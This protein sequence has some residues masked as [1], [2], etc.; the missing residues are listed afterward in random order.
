MA[1]NG[2]NGKAAKAKGPVVINRQTVKVVP[3]DEWLAMQDEVQKLQVGVLNFAVENA[4]LRRQIS[5]LIGMLE[6]NELITR[7][8]AI[9]ITLKGG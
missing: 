1:D 9:N 7:K 5:S 3:M 6:A 4:A 2:T 8:Q